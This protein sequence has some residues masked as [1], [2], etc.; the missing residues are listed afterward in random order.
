MKHKDVARTLGR[1]GILSILAL[2]LM[3]GADQTRLGLSILTPLN[4]ASPSQTEVLFVDDDGI[5]CPGAYVTIQSAVDAAPAGATILVC[6]GIY[7][8]PVAIVGPEKNGIQLLAKGDEGQ[9]TLQGDKVSWRQ[10]VLLQN[11]TGVRVSGFTFRDWGLAARPMMYQMGE[12]IRLFGASGNTLD[13]NY[14]TTST[15]MGITLSFS[16]GNLIEHNAA[17]DNDAQGTGC[18]FHIG[19]ACMNN[20]IRHNVVSGAPLA[21]IMLSNAGT[22]NLVE[23]NV[24]S[25]NG[26]AGIWNG[27][28]YGT[29]I[30]KNV[31][32]NSAGR[33]GNYRDI[34]PD[35][36][37]ATPGAGVYV[38]KSTNVKVIDNRAHNSFAFD[39]MWDGAG[40][41][42]WTGNKCGAEN[43]VGLCD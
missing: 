7:R 22:G 4:A 21:G 33:I 13:H 26:Q 1:L 8:N 10:G 29:T 28:T 11:V 2:A 32:N 3:V 17:V 25:N 43:R 36:F 38:I 41:V 35:D 19:S 12:G 16:H 20:I 23:H 40:T 30:R 9:V 34:P 15:M 14:L 37:Y 42:E 6:P 39:F 31:A 27:G 18:G 5:E 24:V